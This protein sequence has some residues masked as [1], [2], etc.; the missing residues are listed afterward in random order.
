VLG[1]F[2]GGGS[3]NGRTFDT[4]NS[5]ELQN[6]TSTIHGTHSL[7]F[8]VRIRGQLD[9]S[10]SR[11]NF[12]GTFTFG[13]GTLA[14]VLDSNNQPV[15]DGSGQQILAPITSIERYRRTILFQQQGLSAAQIRLLGGGATQ[16]DINAGI[17][18]LNVHQMDVGIFAG[19]E[20]RVRPNLTLSVGLRYELQT[21]IQDWKDLGPRVA[22]AWA[23]RGVTKSG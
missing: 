12:N 10:V 9:D 22:V 16:F 18:A 3:Q 11:Q 6:Y 19:D 2:N 4:Q 1:S 15:L 21:N 5:F 23:P 20:W 7:K 13:G 14:P 17:P 8:G